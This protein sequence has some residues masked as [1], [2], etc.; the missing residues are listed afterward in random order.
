[1]YSREFYNKDLKQRSRDLR[2]NMT[3]AEKKL[4]FDYLRKIPIKVHRQRPMGNFIVDF[5]VP[6][7]KMI[8]EVDGEVHN[9][10]DAKIRDQERTWFLQENDLCVIRF[11]ND[12]VMNNFK[13][14]CKAISDHL[15]LSGE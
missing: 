10:F 9:S 11:S 15:G 3:P 4:W 7:K 13:K 6:S 12:Q 8:I 1:M 2:N 5:Y 14:T